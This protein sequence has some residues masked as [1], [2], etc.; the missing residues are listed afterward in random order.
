MRTEFFGSSN[1]GLVL[2]FL[3]SLAVARSGDRHLSTHTS[4]ASRR[5]CSAVCHLVI[6]CASFG[7]TWQGGRFWSCRRFAHI[8]PRER[9]R[10]RRCNRALALRH[11]RTRS[12][13]AALWPLM[14][15][16][17]SVFAHE[18]FAPVHTPLKSTCWDL[19]SA[20]RGISTG[21][22][23][24]ATLSYVSMRIWWSFFLLPSTLGM[25]FFSFP[26]ALGLA[27]PKILPRSFRPFPSSL[28]VRRAPLA[29][30]IG[31]SIGYKPFLYISLF[32][33]FVF[34]FGILRSLK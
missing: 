27:S 26:L 4:C 10:P 34:V 22:S 31:R 28:R 16:R 21:K 6:D 3:L 14:H 24:I 9:E 18:H 2:F 1:E 23:R 19:P 33:V 5:Y 30:L 7:S 15:R 20:R 8:R 25:S 17:P 32:V 12:R 11:V 29:W 13:E